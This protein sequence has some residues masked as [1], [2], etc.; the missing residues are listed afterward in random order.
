MAINIEELEKELNENN[1]I[2]KIKKIDLENTNLPDFLLE[3]IIK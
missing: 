2:A 1:E 3:Q